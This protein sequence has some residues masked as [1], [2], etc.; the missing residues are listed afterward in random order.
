MLVACQ[1]RSTPSAFVPEPSRAAQ[2]SADTSVLERR[3]AEASATPSKRTFGVLYEGACGRS[4]P[5][6]LGGRAVHGFAQ[7]LWALDDGK[8]RSLFVHQPSS[9][10]QG[11]SHIG[12]VG[13]VDDAHA[14]VFELLPSR[15][16]GY[17]AQLLFAALGWK[18][19]SIDEER[20]TKEGTYSGYFGGLVQQPDGSLWGNV[21]LAIGSSGIEKDMFMAWSPSGARLRIKLPGPDM[22]GAVR[23][24]NG[25]LVVAGRTKDDKPVL[26]RWSPERPVDDLV[27]KD[28][29]RLGAA[30]ARLQI[31]GNHAVLVAPKDNSKDTLFYRYDGS[32]LTASKLNSPTI[33]ATS[34]SFSD[35]HDLLVTTPS[36]E[37]VI[38]RADGTVTRETLPE[39]GVLAEESTASWLLAK[40]GALYIRQGSWSKVPWPDGPWTGSVHP[41]ARI[42]WLTTLG[43]ETLVGT[44]R[45]DAG[46][47]RKK[48]GEVRTVYSTLAHAAPLRCGAPFD[49]DE[50]AEFPAPVLPN[51]ATP[52]LIVGREKGEPARS[53]PAIAARLKGRTGLGE[54]LEFVNIGPDKRSLIA[55]RAKSDEVTKELI[56][57]LAATL[58]SELVCG[59]QETSR[60]LRFDVKAGTFAEAK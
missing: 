39:P 5:Y 13:G 32:T 50:L 7:R 11:T 20:E 15:S 4:Y 57:A 12:V 21:H 23:L 10:N 56:A 25:E 1:P 54:T 17:D 58:Q 49:T 60:T 40:S 45:I 14:W 41:P 18:R 26:R 8:A 22:A 43:T 24:S 33:A 46:F 48:P 59:P 52:M 31:A 19:P 6:R 51:C 53:Y 27:A 16:G 9:W 29:P 37:L 42:E 3:D 28:A 36:D 2:P 30:Y 44:V 55:I 47:G 34:W 38:E 35:A